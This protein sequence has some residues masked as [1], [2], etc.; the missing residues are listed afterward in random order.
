[1]PLRV[2]LALILMPL[3]ILPLFLL[4]KVS[5]DHVREQVEEVRKAQLE[6]VS[7]E[8]LL[9][10]N[11]L[12][13]D[14][15]LKVNFFTEDTVFSEFMASV[16]SEDQT[17]VQ[18]R[19]SQ[20]F[21]RAAQLFPSLSLLAVMDEN[22]K[23]MI[24]SQ[25]QLLSPI[26]L[27]TLHHRLEGHFEAQTINYYDS[28]TGRYFIL[29]AKKVFS[30][31]Q[32]RLFTV[33]FGVLLEEAYSSLKLL[34]GHNN[35]DL[36]LCG[37]AGSLIYH[38]QQLAGNS[39]AVDCLNTI[40]NH[41]YPEARELS[42]LSVFQDTN[43][44]IV[45][46]SKVRDKLWLLVVQ[47]TSD[48]A[49]FSKK[50]GILLA[51]I[52]GLVLVTSYILIYLIMDYFIV[53]PIR[54]LSQVS[55]NIGQGK[56]HVNLHYEGKDEISTLYQSF[57]SMLA[58]I[59]AAYREVEESRRNLEAK[60]NERTS[61]LQ[62][63]TWQ[64]EDAKKQA[65][66]ASRAKSDFL[67]NMSH[68]IRTP[69]NGMLGMAQLLED[70]H[71]SSEQKEFVSQINES[72]QGLLS[73]INDIL[74]LSKIEAGKMVLHTEPTRLDTVINHVVNLLRGTAVEK[75]LKLVCSFDPNMPEFVE[76][77]SLR[78]RQILMNL[79]GNAIKFTE[80]GEVKVFVECLEIDQDLNIVKFKIKVVDTGVGISEDKLQGI[81]DAFSQADGSTTR[82]F[83]GTGLGLSITKRL[84]DMMR[85]TIQVQ[86]EPGKGSA[87]ELLFI[88]TMAQ[89]DT[90]EGIDTYESPLEPICG[91]ILLV[92]D[93]VVN[94]KVAKTML[95]K[96][97]H[98][99]AVATDG[100][101]ALSSM[102]SETFDLI[103]MDVQMPKMNG[104]EVTQSYRQYEKEQ[105]RETTPIIAIT[106]NALKLD[107]E[108]CI[109][110]GMNDF[111]AKPVRKDKL[112]SRVQTW[113]AKA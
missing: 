17:E 79:I 26:Q 18:T 49:L 43:V 89:C 105:N 27:E 70:T 19:L 85:G 28:V 76:A 99:V 13:S 47:E 71:L 32:Q 110:A 30:E 12:E 50:Q 64:L 58:N 112:N 14:L 90:P 42:Q 96:W 40:K 7:G 65:E 24:H 66:I 100:E 34:A 113:L 46:A 45:K 6:T 9:A 21:A 69:L 60:V 8:G 29:K 87:F 55:E 15:E 94:L 84:V 48:L 37:S 109:A 107:Q 81:F 78:L 3:V 72:G 62:E 104:Y 1:M 80:E 68:E 56:W 67:A 5:L 59:H 97:G 22:G 23:A 36:V 63:S 91:K 82:R 20:R 103:L 41:T 33:F 101:E 111:I 98:S 38:T 74:D 51:L 73:L 53:R 52:A 93:N 25:D 57:N 92:E 39:V 54:A 10:I 108:R 77:D 95:S 4:G 75:N 35:V 106:A 11:Q 2:K 88:W 16:D 31:K 86:S 102:K 44:P 61:S 83:G